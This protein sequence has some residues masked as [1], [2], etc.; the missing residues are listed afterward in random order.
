MPTHSTASHTSFLMMAALSALFMGTIGVISRYAQLSAETIT[1]YRLFLGALFMLL[2]LLSSGRGRILLSWP[3]W[4]VLINGGFLAGFIVFYIQGMNYTSMA[5]AIMMIYLAPVAASVIA[6][7]FMGEKLTGHAFL[8]ILLAM[9]GFAMMMEFR[10][11][12]S[13]ASDSGFNHAKGLLYSFLAMLSYTAFILMNRII[14]DKVHV[15]SRSGY[16][17][18]VGALCILPVM[19]SQSQAQTISSVQWGWLIAAGLIPGFLAILFA[20]IALG[21]LPAATFGTLAY[22]EPIAVVTFAW[23]LFDQ[24]LN[25]LQLSGCSIIMLSGIAQAVVSHKQQAIKE[26][27]ISQITR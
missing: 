7:F 18:M 5:N 13:S 26:Q 3:S 10:L 25:T 20:V 1:F 9:L 2:W 15:F 21:R 16:Q 6:H 12:F 23:V 14:P 19:L 27:A 4:P 22:L 24:S 11:D 17:M 8:L